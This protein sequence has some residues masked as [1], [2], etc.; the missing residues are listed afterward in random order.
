MIESLIWWTLSIWFLFFLTNHATIF[1]K[2]RSV[3]MPVLPGWVRDLLQCAFC[4]AFWLLAVFTLFIGATP[5]IVLC[6]PCVLMWDLLFL[7]LKGDK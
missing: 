4:Y 6:P 2:L 5:M 1:G 7:R 3:I